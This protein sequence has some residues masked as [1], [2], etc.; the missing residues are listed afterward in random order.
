M[1]GYQFIIR[2]E[3]QSKK[4]IYDFFCH[5]G[6]AGSVTSNETGNHVIEIFGAEDRVIFCRN[7]MEE[8]FQ[9]KKILQEKSIE[10]LTYKGSSFLIG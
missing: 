8:Y 10:K 6:L 3:N 9:E 7:A 1:K 5:Y 2:E 4:D